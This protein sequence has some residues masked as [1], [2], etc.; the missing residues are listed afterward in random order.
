M[1]TSVLR[2][3]KMH[4]KIKMGKGR[5]GSCRSTKVTSHPVFR[6]WPSTTGRCRWGSR[7]LTDKNLNWLKIQKW[8]I[9]MHTILATKNGS[10]LM[11]WLSKT[12]FKRRIKLS[13]SLWWSTTS[14]LWADKGKPWWLQNWWWIK[15]WLFSLPRRSDLSLNRAQNWL[16]IKKQN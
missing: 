5:T 7:A 8:S 9:E 4:L 14:K 15:K 11:S 13:R 3:R 12:W 10:K 2:R 16:W 1:L 6:L